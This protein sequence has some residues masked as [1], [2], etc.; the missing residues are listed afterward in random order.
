MAKN[1]ANRLTAI[2]TCI[3]F[4]LL[5]VTWMGLR[6]HARSPRLYLASIIVCWA[7][8]SALGAAI[9][10]LAGN[11]IKGGIYGFCAAFTVSF[12]LYCFYSLSIGAPGWPGY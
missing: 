8:G 7:A 3:A 12:P 6:E 2:L 1:K 5:S 10:S 4:V 9:G 11:A